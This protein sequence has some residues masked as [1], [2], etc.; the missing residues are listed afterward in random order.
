MHPLR[1]VNE[2][3]HMTVMNM[4]QAVNSALMQEM[5]R[6]PAV[7]LLGEDIGVNG[8][9]FRVT[10]GLLQRFGPERVID[11]PLAE[12]GIVGCS[13]GMAVSGLRP[14]C[15]IQFSCF[16]PPA[17]DQLLSHAG[18]I[19][20]RSRG[21]YSAPMV[22]RVPYSGGIHAPEHH[23]ESMETVYSAIPGI[24][25]VIPSTP[26]DAKGLLA[27]S[28]RDPDPVLFME[29]KRIYRL[30]KEDVPEEPYALE[31]GKANVVAEGTDLT[32]V[33]WGA[34]MRFARE[35]AAVLAK[36]N[37]SADVID[38]R[39]CSPLD[40][41]TIIASVKKTGRCIIVHEAPRTCGLGA[42]ISAEINEKA[43]LSLEAPVMRV[44]GF[45][46]PFPLYRLEEYYLPNTQRILHAAKKVMEY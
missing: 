39:T 12:L 26:Y 13:I 33:S 37:V 19:R 7:V 14:V 2:R 15:E 32:I 31:L 38:I 22:V 25:V 18:R 40:T 29:P 44:T 46:T 4:V 43:L 36:Q 23:S 45:D 17:F 21:R 11:T 20:N 42:E 6:D 3:D 34:M 27:A 16:L 41:D 1:L 5:Q 9:V 24:K 10:E 35:A 30:L 8:G 28:I